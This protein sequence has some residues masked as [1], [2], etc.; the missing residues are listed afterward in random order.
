MLA[1]AIVYLLFFMFKYSIG[2]RRRR[3]SFKDMHPVSV[4]GQSFI[5]I[6]VTLISGCSAN[7]SKAY[8]VPML[9]GI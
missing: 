8:T 6:R 5:S 1:V 2:E 7:T 9:L 4:I 3:N